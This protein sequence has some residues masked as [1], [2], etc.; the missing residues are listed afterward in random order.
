[1]AGVSNDRARAISSPSTKSNKT[2]STRAFW[3]C[4]YRIRVGGV[5]SSW[6]VAAVC[7]RDL[8]PNR[9]Q[10]RKERWEPDRIASLCVLVCVF[11]GFGDNI[12]SSVYKS[13]RGG[14]WMAYTHRRVQPP[15][16]TLMAYTWS[17]IWKL[18]LICLEY[19]DHFW[20]I[21]IL[22]TLIWFFCKFYLEH[23]VVYSDQLRSV[24]P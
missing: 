13:V 22:C 24:C 2:K 20:I 14:G 3:C 11:G 4:I 23:H 9:A 7:V 6:S 16:E 12:P 17:G 1:M 5:H 15:P 19:N 10:K 8:N 21:N 18:L